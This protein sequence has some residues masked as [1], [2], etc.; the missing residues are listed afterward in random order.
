VSVDRRAVEHIAALAR[1]LL[2]PSEADRLRDDMNRILGHADRLR[3][4][5]TI[6]P[7][8]DPEGEYAP[9]EYARGEDAGGEEPHG[10][11]AAM[12][13]Q[14]AGESGLRAAGL[15]APD[16]LRTGVE[17]FAPEMEAGFFLVPPPAGVT[18]GEEEG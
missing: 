18:A 3:D 4:A 11:R 16:P 2:E 13:E 17:A 10:K 5:A 1:L 8:E 14:P 7:G 6:V 12:P 9:G 15:D